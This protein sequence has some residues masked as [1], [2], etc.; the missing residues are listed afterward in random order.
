[1]RDHIKVSAIAHRLTST[2]CSDGGRPPVADQSQPY[3]SGYTL[4][5]PFRGPDIGTHHENLCRMFEV[6]ED[7]G[8]R[9]KNYL[10][11]HYCL[12]HIDC[13]TDLTISCV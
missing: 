13:I 1:M 12:N 6:W 9:G 3:L 2:S 8:G 11:S 4:T 7:D 5:F 10:E